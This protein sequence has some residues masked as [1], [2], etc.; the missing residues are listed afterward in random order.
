MHK[1]TTAK[2]KEM[3]KNKQKI[4][5]L[6]AYD[7]LTAR[8]AESAGIEGILVGD[9]LGMVV[10]G[11]ENT[12]PVTMEEML[13]HT[14]AVSRGAKLPLIIADMPFLSYQADLKDA[15]YN[16]GKLIKEGGAQAVKLEGGRE[17][18]ETITK[19]VSSG[20]PVMGHLGLT[21]Q[22][23]HQLGGYKIQGKNQKEAQKIIDEAKILEESGIFSLILECVPRELAKTIAESLSIPVIGIGAGEFCDGQIQVF[24]DLVGLC[25]EFT[26]KHAKRYLNL[27][28]EIKNALIKYKEEVAQG[29]F[30]QKE[31]SF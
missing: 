22:S 17:I 14:K 5:L 8:L 27:S 23:I 4:T 18:Q 24:H 20:M 31:N 11:Y 15:L 10:L 25:G 12:L 3:K 2:L 1:I 9:S 29:T 13:H 7:Y 21:P 28:S 19:M 6:S 16:A 26:P 30:P